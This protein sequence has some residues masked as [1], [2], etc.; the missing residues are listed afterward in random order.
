MYIEQFDNTSPLLESFSAF[1]KTLYAGDLWFRD[2]ERLPIKSN[3]QYFLAFDG[4]DIRGR[5][6]TVLNPVL[7]Y[8]GEKT[9]IIGWYECENNSRAAEALLDAATTYLSGCGCV[10]AIGPINGTTWNKY[11]ITEPSTNPPFFLDNYHKPWYFEQFQSNG[12]HTLARYLSTKNAITLREDPR[13]IRFEREL[14]RKRM[15]VRPVNLERFEEDV[16]KI[17]TICTESFKNNFLYSVISWDEFRIQYNTI[18]PVVD[19]SLVL[20]AEDQ[21]SVPLG[22]IFALPNLFENPVTSGIIKTVAIL[23]RSDVRGLGTY[24]VDRVHQTLC[25]KGYIAVFHALMHESNVSTKILNDSSEEYHR[26]VLF[27]KEL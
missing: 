13:I 11:R 21:N 26:Y 27:G 12:F 18:K 10:W 17:F 1:P 4:N 19:P 22:F 24:L 5:L 20:L 14:G 9:G 15:I 7:S 3:A 8:K 23:P 16:E 2:G 25:E 6:A